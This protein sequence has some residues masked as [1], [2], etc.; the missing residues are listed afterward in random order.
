MRARSYFVSPR[1]RARGAIF[2]AMTGAAAAGGCLL[3]TNFDGVA[4]VRPEG[5]GEAGDA[6]E[7]AAASPCSVSD[8]LVCNDFDQP[9]GG[10]PVPGWNQSFNDAGALTLD[11][12]SSVSPPS[13]L[14][15]KVRGTGTAY[16][17]RQVF[18]GIFTSLIITFDIK[19]VSCPAQGNSLT[20]VFAQPSAKASFGFALLSSGVQAIG[21]SI[22]GATTFFALEKQIPDDTWAHVV[23]R[24]L[25]KDV[26]T[27]HFTL[28]VDGMRVVDTDAPSAAML[29]TA[30]LNLGVNGSGAPN[31]C[32]IAFDNYVLDKE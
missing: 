22:N 14:H 7:A 6:S 32:E 4:G 28:T 17:F 3:T 18:V 13:A 20:L 24:I 19:I 16:L 11:S 12:T 10:F 15:A 2:L 5:G 31:G 27:A 9:G 21:S 25:V 1:V 26:S 29:Q 23:Y 30:L 8:H